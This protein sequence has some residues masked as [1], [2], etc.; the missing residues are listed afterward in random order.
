MRMQILGGVAEVGVANA[1]LS[2]LPV[3][4]TRKVDFL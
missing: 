2:L 1:A 4:M 3:K